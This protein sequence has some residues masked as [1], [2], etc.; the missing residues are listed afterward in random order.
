[1]PDCFLTVAERS[2]S[3]CSSHSR[4]IPLLELEEPMAQTELFSEGEPSFPSAVW[5]KRCATIGQNLVFLRGF[6]RE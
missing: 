4:A 1:M 5:E 3:Q 2:D 6:F